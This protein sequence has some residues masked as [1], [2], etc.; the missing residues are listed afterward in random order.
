MIKKKIPSGLII[1]KSLILQQ[2]LEIN[3]RNTIFDIAD[4]KTNLKTNL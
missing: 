3:Q 4:L 1:S 2:L